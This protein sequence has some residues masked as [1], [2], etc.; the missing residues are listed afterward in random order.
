MHLR[1]FSGFCGARLLSRE[2]DQKVMFTTITF[3]TSLDAVYGL[4]G[5][6]YEL[7]V[8]EEAAGQALDRRDERVSHHELVA[9]LQ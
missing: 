3:F 5:D 2:D 4:A 6:G 7:A 9:E 1:T 8:V